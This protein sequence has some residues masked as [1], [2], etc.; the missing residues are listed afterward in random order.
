MDLVQHKQYGQ[1]CE[2]SSLQHKI[3]TVDPGNLPCFIQAWLFPQFD[4]KWGSI[5]CQVSVPPP[6]YGHIHIMCIFTHSCNWRD[7]IGGIVIVVQQ[8]NDQRT[9]TCGWRHPCK[10]TQETHMHV[11]IRADKC[12]CLYIHHFVIHQAIIKQSLILLGK[13]LYIFI[14]HSIKIWA[15]IYLSIY[16]YV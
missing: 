2:W 15:I 14:L 5:G 12:S 6:N 1:H 4:L 9:R 7:H 11:R 3:L 10:N 16:M 8:V 13:H